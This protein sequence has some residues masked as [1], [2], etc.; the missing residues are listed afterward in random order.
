MADAKEHLLTIRASD[1]E[2]DRATAV[3]DH[4]GLNVSSM[5][6]ML[7]KREARDLGLESQAKKSAKAK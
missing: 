5:V 2:N 6:R 1:E 4:Y 3:A 7:V